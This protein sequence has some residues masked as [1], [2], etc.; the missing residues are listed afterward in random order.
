MSSGFVVVVKARPL[1]TPWI[2]MWRI[3]RRTVHLATVMP[4]RFNCR[5]T[6]WVPYT[7]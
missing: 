4:S 5:H 2:P 1:V 7:R 6:L 3:N